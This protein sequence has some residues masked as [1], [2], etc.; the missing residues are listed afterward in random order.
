MV[1][2]IPKNPSRTVDTDS[3]R[4]EAEEEGHRDRDDDDDQAE[5]DKA[6]LELDE[7]VWLEDGE[8]RSDCS[9]EVHPEHHDDDHSPL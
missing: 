3:D 2:H 6:R 4:V 8:T 1:D 7:G 9:E 5:E